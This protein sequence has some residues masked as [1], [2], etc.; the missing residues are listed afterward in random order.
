MAKDSNKPK[1]EKL[2][3]SAK[4]TLLD[5]LQD[6][7]YTSDNYMS[8]L[9]DSWDEKEAM[10][11][12][13]LTDQLTS[14]TKSK[15]F[16]PRLSSIVFE[17]S[18]RVMYQ[19]PRGEYEAVSANDI[20][21]N[22]LMNLLQR[23]F[24]KNAR[25]GGD[26]LL[27]LR[28]FELYSLVYGS[29]FG[30]VP[31]RVDQRKGYVG[32]E[33]NIL[34]IRDA[35]PQPNVMQVDDMDWFG[36]ANRV[37]IQWLQSQDPE[38]W[39]MEAIARLAETMKG[40]IDE[41]K[42]ADE[43]S[44]EPDQDSNKTSFI[45]RSRFPNLKQSSTRGFPK[46]EIITEYRGDTWYTWCPQLSKSDKSQPEILRV[47][48]DPYVK[49]YKLPVIKKDCFPLLGSVIGMGEFERGKS[50]Q[51]ALNSLI[52]LYLDGVKYSI[53]PPLH[54]DYNKTMLSTIKWGPGEKWL[55]QNPNRD[56]QAM[57]NVNPQ[58]IQTFESTYGFMLSALN[59]Q[60]G[61]TNTS[62]SVGSQPTVGRTP[63]ALKYLKQQ[64]NA[65][66][67]WDG[68]MMDRAVEDIMIRWGELI[69]QKLPGK[70][71]VR[72]YESEINQIARK[73]P[74]VRELVKESGG[75]RYAIK[76]SDVK[77]SEGFDYMHEQNSTMKP[78]SDVEA[79]ETFS[80]LT[81]ITKNPGL[82]QAM[83]AEGKDVK[84][85]ELMERLVTSTT[86]KD[87]GKIV[88]DYVQPGK[89]A[90]GE[91]ASGTKTPEAQPGPNPEVT[92]VEAAPAE[93]PSGEQPFIDPEIQRVAESLNISDIPAE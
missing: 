35:F 6:H 58:G 28:L 19:N 31:W 90:T 37:T 14:S 20:G 84:I 40:Q 67:S 25:E 45:E 86:I 78:N 65:R 42:G 32:P 51:K 73:Y 33:F 18:A 69:S 38:V 72:L 64:E 63:E 93:Q 5:T 16:D 60:A 7:L 27:K 29:M 36:A 56:V 54:I 74:D 39:D 4:Q 61:T 92:P 71:M 3:D 87:P 59:S 22:K 12:G 47:V 49:S 66:D 91:V 80:I 82:I 23:W 62:M 81:L 48:K 85:S 53:F 10:L 21:K 1:I 52:N 11:L 34:P 43:G 13:T 15:V 83:R 44:A 8:T 76:P 89:T 17:R 9:R 75:G 2:D 77:S 46:V 26:M 57:A 50:L 68:F 41:G 88:V 30:L 55:M 70:V 24:M 79:E